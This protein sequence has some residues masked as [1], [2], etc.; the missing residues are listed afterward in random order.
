MQRDKPAHPALKK[1][2][3]AGNRIHPIVVDVGDHKTRNNKEQIDKKRQPRPFFP[4]LKDIFGYRNEELLGM[5]E[6]DSCRGDK[7]QEIQM[8]Q[9]T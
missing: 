7:S 5:V 8:K 2:K 9:F 6:Y 3:I 4:D 1:G